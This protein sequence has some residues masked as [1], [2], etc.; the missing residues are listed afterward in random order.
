VTL[1]EVLRHAFADDPAERARL[2][3]EDYLNAH[4]ALLVLARR[5]GRHA[6]CARWS[7]AAVTIAEALE[8]L[9]ECL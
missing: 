4:S 2:R 8:R 6:L 1:D 7:D 3:H 5:H 9:E